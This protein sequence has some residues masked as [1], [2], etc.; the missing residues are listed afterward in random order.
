MCTRFWPG[1][2]GPPEPGTIRLET[3]ELIEILAIPAMPRR[4][5]ERGATSRP[6][7]ISSAPP[8]VASFRREST[9]GAPREQ[10][11]MP[12][13]A[14]S[15]SMYDPHGKTFASTEKMFG[16]IA[17]HQLAKPGVTAMPNNDRTAFALPERIEGRQRTRRDPSLDRK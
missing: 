1:F 11:S 5:G 4:E 3:W 6:P 9:H 2:A 16:Q 12:A 10:S 14:L 7:T 13:M 17:A 15:G 8:S